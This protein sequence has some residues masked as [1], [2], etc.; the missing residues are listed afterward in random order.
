[1]TESDRDVLAAA[2]EMGVPDGRPIRLADLASASG[3]SLSATGRAVKRLRKTGLWR[4]ASHPPSGGPRIDDEAILRAAELCEGDALATAAQIGCSRSNLI[5]RRA[6]L[7]AAGRWPWPDA[8]PG[9]PK[10][11]LSQA[12]SFR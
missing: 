5:K 6:V 12:G 9:R 1:M 7:R 4:W 3:W 11:A 10:A 8:K 2:E